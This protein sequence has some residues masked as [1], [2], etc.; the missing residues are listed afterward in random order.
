LEASFAALSFVWFSGSKPD[1]NGISPIFSHL[2]I[3]AEADHDSW[4]IPITV[5]ARERSSFLTQADQESASEI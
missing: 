2:R 3:P 4:L 1:S 5:P